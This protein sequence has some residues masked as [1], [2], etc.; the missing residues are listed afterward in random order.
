MNVEQFKAFVL[1]KLGVQNGAPEDL[2]LVQSALDAVDAEMSEDGL[3]L[4]IISDELAP[5][6]ILPL[7]TILVAEVGPH[8]GQV[9][10]IQDQRAEIARKRLRRVLAANQSVDDPP[11]TAEYF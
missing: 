6:T 2:E 8:F 1:S 3:E 10:P 11:I 5:Y 7:T 4:G 9:D